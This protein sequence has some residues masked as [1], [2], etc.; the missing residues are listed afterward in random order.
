MS[1]EHCSAHVFL[2]CFS[3]PPAFDLPGKNR[4]D[5]NSK[6]Q[7]TER[8][9]GRLLDASR[10]QHKNY[11]YDPS[12]FSALFPDSLFL[13]LVF[14]KIVVCQCRASNTFLRRR[15]SAGKLESSS[16]K[17]STENG[18]KRKERSTNC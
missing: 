18:R 5:R 13:V 10:D 8:D 15:P 4:K 9:S 6:F 7:K 3:T 12:E 11:L 17:Q 16:A 1:L 2:F 14:L